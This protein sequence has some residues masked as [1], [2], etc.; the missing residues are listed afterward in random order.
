MAKCQVC[1][2]KTTVGRNRS[3]AD[4][5]TARSFGANLK[6]ITFYLK[7]EKKTLTMCTK[8]IKRLKK[9]PGVGKTPAQKPVAKKDKSKK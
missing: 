7:G 9:E 5:R 1:N 4:N 3:H 6:K 2:K 8:C